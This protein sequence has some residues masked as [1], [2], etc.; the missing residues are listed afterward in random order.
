MYPVG[1]CPGHAKH[2]CI[3]VVCQ[4]ACTLSGR[5]RLPRRP[6]IWV[7]RKSMAAGRAGEAPSTGLTERLVE[8]GFETDRL[9]TGT[10]ARVDKRTVDFS[11]GP[12]PPGGASPAP[13]AM[14]ARWKVPPLNAGRSRNE[15]V[16]RKPVLSCTRHRQRR[17]P[18]PPRP[19]AH[20]CQL[21]YRPLV[22]RLRQHWVWLAGVPSAPPRPHLPRRPG[23]AAGRRSGTVVFVRPRG[24]RPAAPAGLLP[25][26][27]HR[28]DSSHPAGETAQAPQAPWAAHGTARWTARGP[29]PPGPWGA[30]RRCN[31]GCMLAVA[32]G[33]AS[34]A[35]HSLTLSS[36]PPPHT[37]QHPTP[38]P[39]HLPTPQIPQTSQ[40]SQTPQPHPN[41]HPLDR[42]TCTRRRCTAAGWMPR[43]RATAPP[44]RT[45][46][47]A[48]P[49][50]SRT[51]W[52]AEGQ[53]T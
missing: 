20:V 40:P 36:I 25:D 46:L 33:C 14:L 12:W 32:P 35:T 41:T 26:P 4:V 3:S 22:P 50:S 37:P 39:I 15:E 19:G 16:L 24:A 49:T 43:G 18:T 8:L 7:G 27:H 47:C 42:R 52:A 30:C 11:G 2:R 13:L 29:R 45:R 9:K 44:S 51:R 1:C 38:T 5:T 6:Q 34:P 28:G 10:P 21:A 31:T 17:C 23:G 53:A 48:L